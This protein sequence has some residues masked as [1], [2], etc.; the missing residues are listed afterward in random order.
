MISLNAGPNVETRDI[1]N[2]SG[3][4]CHNKNKEQHEHRYHHRFCC[5]A[6]RKIK[7][8]FDCKVK[9]GSRSVVCLTFINSSFST[10]FIRDR[11]M[12]GDVE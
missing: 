11:I 7:L 8:V 5:Y 10:R 3:Y 9:R 12:E 4:S 1:S 2:N 6:C